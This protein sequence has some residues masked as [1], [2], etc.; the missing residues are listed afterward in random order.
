MDSLS[1]N[2]I[3][4]SPIRQQ[5]SP[6]S[7][8]EVLESSA[9]STSSSSTES[10]DDEYFAFVLRRLGAISG[11]DDY[12][13]DPIQKLLAE[14]NEA[15]PTANLNVK[16][17]KALI[18]KARSKRRKRKYVLSVKERQKEESAREQQA[19]DE[20]RSSART[21]KAVKEIERDKPKERVIAPVRLASEMTVLS[22]EV[23]DAFDEYMQRYATYQANQ[24]RMKRTSKRKKATRDITVNNIPLTDITNVTSSSSNS[25]TASSDD[26]ATSSTTTTVERRLVEDLTYAT[27]TTAMISARAAQ[28]Q[29]KQMQ[30]ELAL[31]RQR[32]LVEQS[33]LQLKVLRKSDLLL[34]S[35]LSERGIDINQEI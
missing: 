8:R 6:V 28:R 1:D 21:R 2:N 9:S 5:I 32:Y 4:L 17:V 16:D 29:L 25:D 19:Y 11:T 18:S 31:Q 26:R 10:D 30:A 12:T 27:E 13:Q 7:A 20:L 35:L 34:N 23:V 15:F 22:L 3:V 24:K 14:A 33:E